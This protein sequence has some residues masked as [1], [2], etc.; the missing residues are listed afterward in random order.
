M[1]SLRVV[2][3]CT[4]VGA[5]ILTFAGQAAAI[6]VPDLLSTCTA[7]N[8]VS[9]CFKVA[10]QHATASAVTG[11]TS[12]SD[13]TAVSGVASGSGSQARGVFGTSPN[14]IG[15]SGTTTGAGPGAVTGVSGVASGSASDAVGVLGASIG[16]G[17]NGTGVKGTSST[18]NGVYG[19]T[20]KESSLYAGV[21]GYTAT[22]GAAVIHGIQAGGQGGVAVQGEVTDAIGNPVS[23]GVGIRG[24][25][26]G[27]S[28]WGRNTVGK[29][30]VEGD[31]T[32]DGVVGVSSGP[33]GTSGVKGI[34]SGGSW[35][36]FGQATGGGY[37]VYGDNPDRAERRPANT[38]S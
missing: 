31:S 14:G 29:T 6:T 24:K 32:G 26:G 16:T 21:Y 28:I 20:T 35:G 38:V 33:W 8:G 25:D 34:A 1:K 36:V 12:G 23:V 4:W 2:T 7:T 27:M 17:T 19:M 11:S 9:G 13:A 30:A 22:Q 15:V 5:T 18:G 10:N 37:A 3:I